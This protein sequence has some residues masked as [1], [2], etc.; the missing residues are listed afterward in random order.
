MSSVPSPN[1]TSNMLL[2]EHGVR[3]Q[4]TQSYT[5]VGVGKKKTV[6]VEV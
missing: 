6:L 1:Q 2:S 4:T 3:R 5:V